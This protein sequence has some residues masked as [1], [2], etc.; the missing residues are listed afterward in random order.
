MTPQM[1]DTSTPAGKSPADDHSQTAT[2]FVVDDDPAMRD[3]LRWLI[4]SVGLQ[5]AAYPNADAFMA[6]FDPETTGCLVLDVRMP[7]TSGMELLDSLKARGVQV[8]IIMITGHGDVPMA[9]QALKRGALDFLEK[10]FRDQELL[11]QIAKAIEIDQDRRSEQASIAGIRKRLE[12]LTARE[13]EVMELVVAGFANKQVAA[14]LDLSE[15]TIEVHRS[16]VMN[17]MQAHTLPCLVKMAIA[18]GVAEATDC[19]EQDTSVV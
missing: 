11:E 13:R 2:V 14:K 8:P 4:E 17:K 12:T 6:E 1:Q 15:K 3:S 18:V 19:A 16:R 9:V 7:G 10:P 5:V